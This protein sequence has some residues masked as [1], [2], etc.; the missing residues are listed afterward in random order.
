MMRFVVSVNWNYYF[1]K[2]CFQDVSP[3]LRV[4]SSPRPFYTVHHYH[5][6]YSWS[7]TQMAER[8][9]DK[10]RK[11]LSA[12][13]YAGRSLEPE[14][15]LCVMIHHGLKLSSCTLIKGWTIHKH[16]YYGESVMILALESSFPDLDELCPVCPL[17]IRLVLFSALTQNVVVSKVAKSSYGS[18]FSAIFHCREVS[19]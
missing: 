14:L 7:L 11:T 10:G 12:S 15:Y 13:L 17:S 19:F 6:Q 5:T 1:L 4:W 8:T 16:C 3:Q 18:L 9:A 2:H